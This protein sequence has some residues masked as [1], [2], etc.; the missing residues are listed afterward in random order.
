MAKTLVLIDGNSLVFRAFH[1]LPPMN[2]EDGTPVNAAYG[3]FTM[4][5]RILE[6]HT[7]LSGCGVRCRAADLPQEAVSGL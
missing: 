4:L 3:F 5:L 7:G 1:A 6:D 2:R